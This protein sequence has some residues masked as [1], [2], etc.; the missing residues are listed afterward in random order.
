MFGDRIYV[1]GSHDAFNRDVIA[2][3]QDGAITGF[4]YFDLHRKYLTF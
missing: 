4:I 3:M 2:N 1:Y